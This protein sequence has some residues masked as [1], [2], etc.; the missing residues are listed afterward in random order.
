MIFDNYREVVAPEEGERYW[1]IRPPLIA[2][3]VV[4]LPT[5]I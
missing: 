2:G 1:I 4:R 3:N 5:A